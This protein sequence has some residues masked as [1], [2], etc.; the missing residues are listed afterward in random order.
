MAGPAAFSQV[1]QSRLTALSGLALSPTRTGGCGVGALLRFSL[2]VAVGR[3][4]DTWPAVVPSSLPPFLLIASSLLATASTVWSPAEP[5]P[6]G[7]R[8]IHGPAPRPHRRR[9]HH[10]SP[11]L[12]PAMAF[13]SPSALVTDLD[14][15]Y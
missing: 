15:E 11:S 3:G 8:C 9:R 13:V 7:E 14:T 10:L 12:I 2:G 4:S 1:P 6:G 5:G